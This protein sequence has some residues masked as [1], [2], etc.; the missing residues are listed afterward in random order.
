MVGSGG[1]EQIDRTSSIFTSNRDSL[2]CSKHHIWS[3]K[4]RCGKP[5]FEKRARA[6]PKLILILTMFLIAESAL[7]NTHAAEQRPYTIEDFLSLEALGSFLI[8]ATGERLVWEQAPA[9]D[10]IGDYSFTTLGAWGNSGF[11]IR[12]IDLS[13]PSSSPTVLLGGE[14]DTTSYWIDGFSPT[15]QFLAFYSGQHGKLKLGVYDFESRTV[16]HFDAAPDVHWNRGHKSVWISDTEFVFSDRGVDGEPIPSSR[17]HTARELAEAWSNAWAGR[18]SVSA[19]DS[20][21]TETETVWRAGRL[22]IA[23]AKTG[24]LR[25][26]ADGLHNELHVSS[27]GRFLATL[28]QG[29]LPQ[30]KPNHLNK[31]WVTARSLLFV[32]DLKAENEPVIVAREQNVFP[33][34]LTWHPSSNHL[35]YFAWK[36]NEGVQTGRFY[37]F[38]VEENSVSTFHHIGLDLA[39]AR[40]RGWSQRP[41]RAYWVGDRLAIVARESENDDITP[42]FTYRDILRQDAKEKDRRPDWFLLDV[43]GNS[44]NLTSEFNEVSPIPLF[45]DRTG[46]GVLADGNAWKYS[47]DDEQENLTNILSYPL[48]QSAINETRPSHEATDGTIRLQKSSDHDPSVVF[49][50]T[51]GKEATF[52]D[53]P[54]KDAVPLA[55]SSTMKAVLYRLDHDSGN[56]LVLRYRDGRTIE[57]ARLN[58]HLGGV[59]KTK[60]KTINHSIESGGRTINVDSCLLLPY[61]YDPKRRYPVIVDVYPSRGAS[62]TYGGAKEWYDLGGKP[63]LF[64]EHLLAAEDYI[65][66]KPNVPRMLVRSNEGPL[67]RLT[68]VVLQGVDAIID[69]GYAD[70][71]RLGLFGFSQGAFASLLVSS[72][73][74][75]F[76]AVVSV[77][78]WSDMYSHYFEAPYLSKIYTDE[79]PFYGAAVRYESTAGSDYSIGRSPFDDPNVYV[80]NSP[81]FRA[82]EIAAPVLLVHSDFDT[83]N[84]A[85]YEKMF[86][87]LY[88]Q[89]KRA[90]FLRYWG[91]GHGPSSPENIRHMW[92]EISNWYE[93]NLPL[94]R[95]H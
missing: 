35:A 57:I 51:S 24:T 48:R 47:S 32:Y 29:N 95:E 61:N 39:S 27:D 78:G 90:R 60:W 6:L 75:R 19:V 15:G 52:I 82:R 89:R 58:E 34:T 16:K 7:Q 88:L 23:N 59:Y 38:N 22:R 14:N 25:T 41:E 20:Y 72:Q 13:D 73:T 45:A 11:K 17:P 66:F 42:Q 69:Q 91:E 1:P 55:A 8:D 18:K 85:Q 2:G 5:R 80:R 71:D 53:T 40:E 3:V 77:N 92:N 76:K 62:C 68:D 9:Y 43:E 36:A 33:E 93:E 63:W 79:F 49:I 84:M 21:E 30:P 44:R 31:D 64:S 10:Q 65:V 70:S 4:R 83:F 56:T 28:K 26:V 46:I 37:G 74:T 67:E 94:G 54:S 81:L 12:F 50:N 87:A 86:T